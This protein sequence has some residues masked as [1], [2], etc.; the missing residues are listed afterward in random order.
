MPRPVSNV[1]AISSSASGIA[2]ATDSTIMALG[3]YRDASAT[4]LG[5]GR[6]H[7]EIPPV[8]PLPRH[9]GARPGAAPMGHRPSVSLSSIMPMRSASPRPSLGRAQP[10]T[11]GQRLAL[12]EPTRPLTALGGP[13]ERVGDGDDELDSG[14]ELALPRR[15]SLG[16]L[17]IP[18]RIT[19]AQKK[20]EEDLERVKQFAKAVEGA[21]LSHFLSFSIKRA[22]F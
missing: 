3:S 9:V 13:I 19:N 22:R 2:D 17:R 20:I 5:R 1:P 8:P 14:D 7:G 18:A 12:D 4:R 15:N 16:D 10:L 21:S 6:A 11:P